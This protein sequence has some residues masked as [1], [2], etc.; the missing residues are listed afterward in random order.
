MNTTLQKKFILLFSL[1]LV[2]LM[3]LSAPLLAF[4]LLALGRYK[5]TY[6]TVMMGRYDFE[7][8]FLQVISI[9]PNTLNPETGRVVAADLKE[10]IQGTLPFINELTGWSARYYMIIDYAAAK[11]VVDALGG[12]EFYIPYD[13]TIIEEGKEDLVFKQG[14]HHLNG[15]EARRLLRYRQGHSPFDRHE[16]QVMELQQRF[17]IALINKA[18]SNKLK[19]IRAALKLGPAL[20]TNLTLGNIIKLIFKGLSTGVEEI[21]YSLEVIP[22]RYVERG[23]RYIYLAD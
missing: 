5:G 7:Q 10:D 11:E 3:T 23:G 12:V 18:L 19:L 22:G 20:K 6:E 14:E 21:E 4:D 8:S 17:L 16:L 1:M 2:T 9:P 15:E 13:L